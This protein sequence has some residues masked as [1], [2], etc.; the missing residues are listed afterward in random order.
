MIAQD[1]YPARSRGVPDMAWI[2]DEDREEGHFKK[3][4]RDRRFSNP[5]CLDWIWSDT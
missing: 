4:R 5:P 2:D 3:R 1:E